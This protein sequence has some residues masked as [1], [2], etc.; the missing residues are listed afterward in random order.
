MAMLLVVAQFI[1]LTLLPYA[2][3]GFAAGQLHRMLI[4]PL[5]E[6]VVNLVCSLIGAR[7][8]GAV[9]V[10]LGTL[11][12]A[13]AGV[14][15]HFL[16]SMP[17]TDRLKFNRG[18]FATGG[19]LRPVICCLPVFM[20]GMIAID[21]ALNWIAQAAM[22]AGCELLAMALL[23]KVNFAPSERRQISALTLQLLPTRKYDPAAMP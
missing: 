4:S 3:F 22:I 13:V 1:R 6:G 23:W 9:G 19:I 20:M 18:E 2:A 15:L 12:G 10:A 16:N 7:Y 14:L 21:H 8:L 11:I 5:G 17:R